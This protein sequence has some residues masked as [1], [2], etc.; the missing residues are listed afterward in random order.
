MNRFIP[1]LLAASLFASSAFAG[2]SAGQS[3]CK[4]GAACCSQQASCCP[5]STK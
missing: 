5:T 3:C 4:Q 1:L 2:E